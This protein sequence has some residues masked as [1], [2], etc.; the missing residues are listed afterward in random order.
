MKLIKMGLLIFAV[1]FSFILFQ[2]CSA[3]KLNQGSFSSTASTE[4]DPRVIVPGVINCGI[5]ANSTFWWEA[6]PTTSQ[7]AQACTYGGNRFEILRQE[8]EKK[9]VGGIVS[10]TGSTR[11]NSEGFSGV[12]NAAPPPPPATCGAHPSGS[13]WQEFD[14]E[15][16]QRACPSSSVQLTDIF[17][18][19]KNMTCTNGLA[20]LVSAVRGSLQST[21]GVCPTLNCAANFSNASVLKNAAAS[22][23]WNCVNASTAK[24]D[25]SNGLQ[26]LSSALS[27]SVGVSTATAGQIT[28]TVTGTNSASANHQAVATLLVRECNAGTTIAS[29]CSALANG[30]AS[31]TCAADGMNYG[32]CSYNCDAGFILSGAASGSPACTA[33]VA[34]PV[35][36]TC[37]PNQLFG[38]Y[39]SAMSGVGSGNYI[40]KV[41][42][43]SNV[44]LVGSTDGD[45]AQKLAMARSYNLKVIFSM[46]WHFWNSDGTIRSDYLAQWQNFKISVKGSEDLIAAI[47]LADEPYWNYYSSHPDA[48]TRHMDWVQQWIEALAKAVKND[49][50]TVKTAFVEGYPILEKDL[51]LPTPSVDWI[52]FDCYDGFEHCGAT[53]IPSLIVK[54]KAQLTANQ[55]MIAVPQV[56]KPI[57]SVTVTEAQMLTWYR[58]WQAEWKNNSDYALVLPFIWSNFS[59]GPAPT[60]KG[61]ESFPDYLQKEAHCLK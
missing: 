36:P 14:T 29:G 40:E 20:T 47:Y 58:L 33:I 34:T 12:C 5:H 19:T 11:T 25:C 16:A 45:L 22:L 51:L 50:P 35:S 39:G 53:S 56:G 30:S 13:T 26:N 15:N 49:W 9:C 7:V 60:W 57:S 42:D 32:S 41:K 59:D 37:N 1:C 38:F 27:G 48:T 52:G 6:A 3:P 43:I 21:S 46:R 8:S 54:L 24:Y 31:R 23:N 61:L 18:R 44:I 2:N 28:C 10:S 4:K 17:N 55:K